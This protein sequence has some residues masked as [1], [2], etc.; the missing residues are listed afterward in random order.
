MVTAS[1][2]EAKLREKLD[3][4]DV[5]SAQPGWAMAATRTCV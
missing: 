4:A 3:A 5:V 2:V 1:E